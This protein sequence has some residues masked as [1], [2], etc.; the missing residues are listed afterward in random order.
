MEQQLGATLKKIRQRQGS[1]R[2]GNPTGVTREWEGTGYWARV[3]MGEIRDGD[4]GFPYSGTE[5]G[6]AQVGG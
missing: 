1:S 4:G 2:D 5:T 6:D 3:A